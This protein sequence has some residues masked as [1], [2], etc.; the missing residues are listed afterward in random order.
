[1]IVSPD[2]LGVVN[3]QGCDH[4]DSGTR[5]RV[6]DIPVVA[7]NRELDMQDFV[8]AFSPVILFGGLMIACLIIKRYWGF[9]GNP[10]CQ[11]EWVITAYGRGLQAGN[12]FLRCKK[13]GGRC[14]AVDF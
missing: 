14:K 12:R 10:D 2:L 9:S 7:R 3:D 5:F 1:M 8:I 4:F 11:H 6:V 13:C